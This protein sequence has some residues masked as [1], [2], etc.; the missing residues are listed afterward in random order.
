MEGPNLESAHADLKTL[1]TSYYSRAQ[2]PGDGAAAVDFDAEA[3]ALGES[4]LGCIA[5]MVGLKPG[6]LLDR[7]KRLVT[8]MVVS[9][10]GRLQAPMA[11]TSPTAR[12]V[13]DLLVNKYRISPEAV[14]VLSDAGIVSNAVNALRNTARRLR[15]VNTDAKTSTYHVLFAMDNADGMLRTRGGRTGVWHRLVISS[16]EKASMVEMVDLLDEHW[17]S[18]DS[19]LLDV[20]PDEPA[21]GAARP[22][23]T[24]TPTAGVAGAFT[25]VY[26]SSALAVQKFLAAKAVIAKELASRPVSGVNDGAGAEARGQTDLRPLSGAR[27]ANASARMVGVVGPSTGTE[28]ADA[29][30]LMVGVAGELQGAGRAPGGRKRKAATLSREE[31]SALEAVAPTPPLAVFAPAPDAPIPP[32]EVAPL[33]EITVPDP[34]KA[35]RAASGSAVVSH[36]AAAAAGA[37][38]AERKKEAARVLI[39]AS[40]FGATGTKKELVVPL[41]EVGS[42]SDALEEPSIDNGP[43]NAPKARRTIFESDVEIFFNTASGPN[44]ARLIEFAMA[45]FAC[46]QMARLRPQERIPMLA[47]LRQFLSEE[48]HKVTDPAIRTLFTLTSGFSGN[49]DDVY[50]ALVGVL[51]SAKVGQ[52]GGPALMTMVLDGQLYATAVDLQRQGFK[53]FDRFVFVLGPT[54]E[55]WSAEKG[56]FDRWGA[57]I[58]EPVMEALG[59]TTK[60]DVKKA[61]GNKNHRV[62]DFLFNST[63]DGAL[64]ALITA[65]LDSA[66]A[67][68]Q[69]AALELIR[70]DTP[71]SHPITD[72]IRGFYNRVTTWAHRVAEA[73]PTIRILLSFVLDEGMLLMAQYFA[74]RNQLAEL[75]CSA[76]AGLYPLL[77]GTQQL[78][79]QELLAT[80]LIQ[81]ARMD[82]S[83]RPLA[84]LALFE[85]PTGNPFRSDGT[86]SIQERMI[87]L[88]KEAMRVCGLRSRFQDRG[89]EDVSARVERARMM[90][91][92]LTD[93][94]SRTADATASQ[95]ARD[96]G[97]SLERLESSARKV[98]HLFVSKGAFVPRESRD[99]VNVLGNGEILAT[100]YIE[101]YD[102]RR[103]LGT[104]AAMAYVRAR[105][106]NKLVARF[107]VP[108]IVIPCSKISKTEHKKAVKAPADF[109]N[110]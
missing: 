11:Y 47:R 7:E 108:G 2:R 18:L 74:L 48:A 64:R 13:Q 58:L 68:P 101:A 72:D 94:R 9:L 24:A 57:L 99:L 91:A 77:F 26:I 63:L 65:Y 54:H 21:A 95:F 35:K 12:W 44:R 79:Y 40:A 110:E 87:S 8:L 5:G 32:V 83:V 43:A 25:P 69:D 92:A 23:E 60:A 42:G 51:A 105:I 14:N 90:D 16:G 81:L 3:E 56:G 31:G 80:W 100:K 41:E 89:P 6:D 106:S 97:V 70:D 98:C 10:L 62:N 88:V 66:E 36:P 103:A 50:D 4:L 59:Y 104:T 52:T 85:S 109:V 38:Y 29:S 96:E 19:L 39:A 84:M 49:R 46:A 102:T 45:A 107:R 82:D 1:Q 78:S 17:R 22:A 53:D 61:Q 20:V 86:D 67:L 55:H 33:A 76:T 37:A 71:H 34:K 75:Y 73:N 28:A 15:N 93:L 30:A 27:A